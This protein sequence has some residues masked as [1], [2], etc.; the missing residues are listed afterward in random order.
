MSNLK[1][2]APTLSHELRI[3]TL[4]HE[5]LRDGNSKHRKERH[6]S[7]VDIFLEPPKLPEMVDQSLAQ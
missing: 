6:M 7:T 4:Q 2:T 5:E 1:G 3:T